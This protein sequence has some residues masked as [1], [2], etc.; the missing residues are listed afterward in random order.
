MRGLN[1][2]TLMMIS[3][4]GS[5]LMI[6]KIRGSRKTCFKNLIISYKKFVDLKL[7]QKMT[8]KRSLL[9]RS[10]FSFNMTAKFKL[11]RCSQKLM[12]EQSVFFDFQV[13]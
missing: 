10:F 12:K 9:L 11:T 3:V 8:N 5:A 7:V 4:K 13:A 6:E 1:N 2:K